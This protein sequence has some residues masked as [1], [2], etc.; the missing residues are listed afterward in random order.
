MTTHPE[1]AMIDEVTRL[2]E[3]AMDP[4]RST[5]WL[6]RSHFLNAMERDFPTLLALAR[7]ALAARGVVESARK[8]TTSG[9]LGSA[10]LVNGVPMGRIESKD[11]IEAL[12]AH[13][14]AR[15][16]PT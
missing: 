3:N 7:E 14:A 15:K 13:D 4:S 1:S 16:E 12:A 2:H 11:I 6:D 8:S 9:S 10:I 5:W